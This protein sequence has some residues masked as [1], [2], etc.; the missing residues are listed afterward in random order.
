MPNQLEMSALIKYFDI[1]EGCNICYL[2]FMRGLQD[3]LVERRLN[4]VKKAFLNVDRNITGKT[5]IPDLQKIFDVSM[6]P[7]FLSGKKTKDKLFSE[8][9]HHLIGPKQANDCK[10]M[11]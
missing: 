10:I 7:G 11:K 2:E 3:P 8:F 1:D 6:D 5:T 4:I 9:L